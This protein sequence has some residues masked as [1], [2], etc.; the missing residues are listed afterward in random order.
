MKVKVN[1]N[2]NVKR[3]YVVDGKEYSSIEEM[4][5]DI[6]QA[7]ERAKHAS[8]GIDQH[9]KMP[10][11]PPGV[12]PVSSTSLSGLWLIVGLILLIVF[13]GLYYLLNPGGSR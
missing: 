11:L 4:P 3:K 13:F 8:P 7:F 2:V 6:R 5:A 10:M 12:T 9:E 1:F